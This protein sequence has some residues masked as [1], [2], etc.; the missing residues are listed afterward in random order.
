[1][2]RGI[3]LELQKDCLDDNVFV[4]RILRKA[5]VIASKLDL[6]EL[7]QW[8]DA[9]L[10]GYECSVDELPNHRKGIG[11][12]KFKNPYHGWCPI[13][14]DGGSLGTA[15]RTVIFKQPVS[16][17]EALAGGDKKASLIMYYH[18]NIEALLQQQLVTPMECALHFPKSQVTSALDYVRNKMLDWTL[19]LESRGIIGNGH[20][21]GSDEK[22]EAKMV[23]NNIYG[24]NVGVLG[25]V[26]RDANNFQST[27]LTPQSIAQLAAQIRQTLPA[28]PHDIGRQIETPLAELEEQSTHDSVLPEA[29]KS[30]GS[31]R[32]ILQ[33]AA[34][35]LAASGVIGAI[36]LLCS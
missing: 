14:A 8:I 26:G 24:G 30:L 22:R 18:P 27:N 23:T 31:I 1:M 2:Q 32:N 3:V 29:A 20:T 21:F 9:E 11:N 6:P 33:G 25:S 16:E 12:P 34:G 13:L 36:N 17:L 4:S 10:G 7:R 28:L 5:K 19:E 15:I 35:N